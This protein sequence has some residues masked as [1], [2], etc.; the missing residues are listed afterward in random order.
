[1]SRFFLVLLALAFSL[2]SKAQ[3]DSCRFVFYNVENLFDTIDSPNTRDEEFLPEGDRHWNGWK[4]QQKL[5][6]I[7]KTLMAVKGWHKLSLIGLCEIENRQVLANLIYKTPLYQYDYQI[8]HTDSP[9][10]RGVDVALLYNPDDFSMLRSETLEIRFPFD[11]TDKT[12]D[13]LYAKGIMFGA[14]TLHV[15]LNHWPSRYGGY[16]KTKKKRE[17]VASILARKIDSIAIKQKDAKIL[18]AGDFNDEPSDSSLEKLTDETNQADLVNLLEN[19]Q[20]GTTKYRSQWYLFDQ[21]IV[22][23]NLLKPAKGLHALNP[24]IGRFPFLLTEDERY[25]GMKV[26]RTFAGPRYIGGYSDHLPVFLDLKYST[27]D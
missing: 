6:K 16:M 26:F 20:D 10:E 12:R 22:S 2:S 17:F 11:S 5:N 25:G 14:D 8:I 23:N 7:Y 15:F 18:I 24:Q 21:L 4:Y 9:D 27:Q 13:I 3:P 19:T 1:M